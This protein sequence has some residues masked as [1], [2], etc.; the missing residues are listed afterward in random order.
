M[1]IKVTFST[2]TTISAEIVHTITTTDIAVSVNFQ[3]PMEKPFAISAFKVFIMTVTKI[4]VLNVILLL[5]IVIN[6]QLTQQLQ[7]CYS[8]ANTAMVLITSILQPKVV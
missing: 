1:K 3:I 7:L 5:I 8:I 2:S 4:S 6:V